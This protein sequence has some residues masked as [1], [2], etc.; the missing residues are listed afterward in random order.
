MTD[1]LVPA[2]VDL[3]DFAFMPLDVLRLRD[4]D[5]VTHAS[6]DAFKAAVLLWC[7][8]W[9]QVPAGSIPKDEK[10]LARHSG[11]GSAW[12]KL[13]A[14][15]LRGFVEC[16]DG[17]LYHPVVAEKALEAWLK[18]QEQ[19]VRTLKA[20]IAGCEKRITEAKTDHDREHSQS[21]LH[22]LLQD[23]SHL[24]S[25]PLSHQQSLQPRDSKG[26][27]TV[28]GQGQG[29]V[30]LPSGNGAAARSDPVKDEIW[31]SGRT[32]LEGQGVGKAEAGTFLGGL[33]KEY[34]QKLVIEAVRDAVKAT[35]AEVKGWLV[36]RC[37]ERRAPNRQTALEDRNAAAARAALEEP[38][39]PH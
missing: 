30:P 23:L 8:S 35:P 14:D 21:Q 33:C 3:R 16:S 32:L 28:K 1:P 6:G 10:W 22:G 7:V 4:S 11:A 27:G 12:K 36:A 34:G 15:A 18:K 37:Q 24:L 31:K 5:L 29:L 39:G 19:R 20:R 26:T 13:R 17:R 25:H 2:E 9:H 38:N